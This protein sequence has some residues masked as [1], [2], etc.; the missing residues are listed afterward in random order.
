[1]HIAKM[2]IPLAV[3]LSYVAWGGAY[4]EEPKKSEPQEAACTLEGTLKVH[5]KYLYRYYIAGLGNAQTCALFGSE[6]FKEEAFKEI[7][8]GSRIRVTG[9]LGTRYHS[10]GTAANLSPF[11]PTWIIY[12]DVETVKVLAAP[13][14]PAPQPPAPNP[15]KK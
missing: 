2:N 8:E 14:V 3:V 9:R 4:A 12:M 10:G 15:P 13:V 1:M 6:E 7:K 11:P 5:P